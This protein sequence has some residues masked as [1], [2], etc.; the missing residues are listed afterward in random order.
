M[1]EVFVCEMELVSFPCGQVS[2][3]FGPMEPGDVQ[4]LLEYIGTSEV[5]K[6][7]LL[8]KIAEHLT[9]QMMRDLDSAR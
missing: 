6:E 2:L 4:N 9:S 7:T 8:D 1:S 3:G 5:F